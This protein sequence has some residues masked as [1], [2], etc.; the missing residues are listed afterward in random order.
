M[1]R[2][3][4]CTTSGDL[5]ADPGPATSAGG[6]GAAALPR[7]GVGDTAATRAATSRARMIIM[8]PD[9]IRARRPGLSPAGQDDPN[10][11]PTWAESH[12][13]R[14]GSSM[15]DPEAAKT[16]TPRCSAAVNPEGSSHFQPARPPAPTS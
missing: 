8:Y 10:D 7:A 9:G 14:F 16:S 13:C 6:G 2:L 4:A 11:Q 5:A 15:P 3:A 1:R 12:G